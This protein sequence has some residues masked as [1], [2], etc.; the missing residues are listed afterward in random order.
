MEKYSYNMNN[1]PLE[2]PEKLLNNNNIN[3]INSK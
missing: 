3:N 2:D 1:H